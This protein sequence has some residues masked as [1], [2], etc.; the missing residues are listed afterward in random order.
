MTSMQISRNTNSKG[1]GLEISYHAYETNILLSLKLSKHFIDFLKS[2]IFVCGSG[3]KQEFIHMRQAPYQPYHS[4]L[5]FNI[6]FMG[7]EG[8][9]LGL[10][11][12]CGSLN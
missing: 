12:W 7:R 4:P 10:F 5:I 6:G 9:M 3:S 11:I 8:Y 2:I 1:L